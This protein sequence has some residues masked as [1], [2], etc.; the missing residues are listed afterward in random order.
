M[1][2]LIINVL[3]VFIGTSNH[4]VLHL[5][6]PGGCCSGKARKW[7]GFHDAMA[8]FLVLKGVNLLL[9]AKVSGTVK[10]E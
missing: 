7:T 2:G 5:C 9:C 6:L 4:E 10:N 1:T 8:S 3:H